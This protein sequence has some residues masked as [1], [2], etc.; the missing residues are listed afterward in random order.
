MVSARRPARSLNGGA[1]ENILDLC[2]SAEQF[3]ASLPV[4][5]RHGVDKEATFHDQA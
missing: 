4:V 3:G 2:G 5:R 1:R